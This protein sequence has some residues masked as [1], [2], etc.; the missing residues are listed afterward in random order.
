MLTKK[1]VSL[2]SGII[3]LT[4]FTLDRIGTDKLCGGNQ[5]TSCMQSVH[6]YFVIFFPIFVVFLFALITYW[7][8]EEIYQAWFRFA[9]WWIPLSI[10][11]I[12]LAPEYSSNILS[13]VEKGSVAIAMSAIFVI[14]SIFIIAV[15]LLRPSR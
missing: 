13:S 15:K 3:S 10:L 8:R 1:I 2:V 5:Y 9:R 14:V 12:F 4:L 11:L 7:M 6:S